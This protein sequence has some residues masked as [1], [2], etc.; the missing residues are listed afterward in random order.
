M[1]HG[2]AGQQAFLSLIA[3]PPIQFLDVRNLSLLKPSLQAQGNKEHGAMRARHAM[4][5]PN[6]QVIVMIVRNQH[7]M[8]TR[9][10]LERHAR[11]DEPLRTRKANG[12]RSFRPVWVRENIEPIELN[13]QGGM[14]D[15]CDGRVSVIR[16]QPRAVIVRR[17]QRTSS[18]M[19]RR[20]PEAGRNKFH[21][22]PFSWLG[23]EWI[24]VPKSPFEPMAIR[25]SY[26]FHVLF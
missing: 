1:L 20:G 19:E 13:Q 14:A 12:T 11:R 18:R 21:P 4:H 22:F 2:N 25:P 15:P 3:I 6:I 8:N 23:K 5:S 10:T 9:Q 7:E 16:S 17:Y 26:L 24:D